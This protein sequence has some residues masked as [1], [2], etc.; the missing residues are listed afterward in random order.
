[1]T[2]KLLGRASDMELEEILTQ[3]ELSYD[4]EKR[5]VAE[6]DLYMNTYTLEV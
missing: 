2:S 3:N 5:Y 4:K 1:M 6:S